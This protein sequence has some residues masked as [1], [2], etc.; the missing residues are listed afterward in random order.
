[1]IR[2]SSILESIQQ[3]LLICNKEGQIVY[4]NDAYGDF[5]NKKLS[6]VI[7][8]PIKDIR[9]GSIVSGVIKKGKK[10]ENVYRKEGEQEYFVNVYPIIENENINGTISIV[11]SID[12]EKLKTKNKKTLQ[13]RVKEFEKKEIEEMLFIYGYETENKIEVAKELGISLATLYNK[14]KF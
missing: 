8:T 7:G 10:R 9:T 6:D 4:F 14:L 12:K 2:S 3:G 1:M 5:I 13:E 11:T